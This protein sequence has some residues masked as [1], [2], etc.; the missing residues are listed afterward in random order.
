LH[1]Y[2]KTYQYLYI[3]TK[4][5]LAELCDAYAKL[6]LIAI[7]TEFVRTQTLTPM[8]G[9]IQV[10]D[11][12]NVALI[13]PVAIKDLSAFSA[14]LEDESIV[15]VAHSCSEDLE[16]LWHHLGVLPAPVFDTQ[17]AAGMLDMGASVGYANLVEQLFSIQVDKGESRTDWIRR[18]LSDAQCAYASADVTHLMALYEHISEKVAAKHKTAW[19]YDEIHQLGLKK[20]TL[21]P[22]HLAYFNLKN[23]WKL[24]GKQLAAL[25]MLARWRLEVAREENMSVNF[26]IKE[27]ALFEIA[28]SLPDTSQALFDCHNL[29]S[30]QARLYKDILLTICK[31]AKAMSPEDFPPRIQRLT[32]FSGYKACLALIKDVADKIAIEQD[33]PVAVFSSKKQMNQLLKWCWFDFDELEAQGFKPDLLIGWRGDLMNEYIR[34]TKNINSTSLEA[35]IVGHHEIKR[36]L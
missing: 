28:S 30:K 6:D 5:Q 9:L 3:D 27:A 18:P 26:V 32:E 8:L 15:K 4:A 7:D 1:P 36:S 17:F 22:A 29:Y 24:R 14:I 33:I 23:N 21:F 25:Q 35:L 12:E 2:K 19:I 16:A 20:S 10:F 13:D 11:K 34:G 31:T